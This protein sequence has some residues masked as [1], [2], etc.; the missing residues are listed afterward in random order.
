[1]IYARVS[2]PKQDLEHQVDNLWEFVVD[3]LGLDGAT[4]MEDT[5]TGANVDR[6]GYREL[7]ENA[8]EGKV[9]RVVVRDITRLGRNLRDIQEIVYELVEDLD[10][11]LHILEDDIHIEP[12]EELSLQDK[13]LLS[14]L[15]WGAELEAERIRENT[16]MAL[17]AAREAGKWTT[18]PPYGFTTD[19]DGYLTANEKYH[20]ALMAIYAVE[21][22]GWSHRQA[23]RYSGVPRRTIPGILER[24]ALYLPD[25]EVEEIEVTIP[26]SF[27]PDELDDVHE[28]ILKV[29]EPGSMPKDTIVDVVG[30]R[31]GYGEREAALALIELVARGDVVAHPEFEG[32][33]K[34]NKN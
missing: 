23:A 28:A 25:E 4:V 15:G 12:G 14:V 32:C 2:T 24:K 29:L 3:E 27:A 33:W 9:G 20:N 17:Q 18:R 7:L 34:L 30:E 31:H 21:T 22:L 8:R 26:E 10:V 6:A 11:G 16:R 1:M 5:S 13:M 19:D